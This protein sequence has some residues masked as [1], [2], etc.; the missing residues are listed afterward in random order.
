MTC[1][2]KKDVVLVTMP[3]SDFHMPS[4][5]LSLLKACLTR[6]GVDSVVQYEHL[7]FIK[8]FGL[9][10]FF[11]VQFS[12]GNF[13][14]G[15]IIFAKAAH[16]KTL[17]TPNEFRDWLIE[18]NIF[19]GADSSTATAQSEKT[20]AFIQKWQPFAEN[21]IE[22]A[23]ARVMAHKPKI[24]AFV[25]MFQQMNA[26]IALARRLKQEE[27][28]PIILVGGSNC[29]GDAGIALLEHFDA[30]DY[31]FIG[32]ADE[33]FADVCSALLRDGEIPPEKF[34][35]G[36]W[37]TRA[38]KPKTLVHR[39]T[40]NLDDLPVPDFDDFFK[41]HNELFPERKDRAYLM[42]EGSRGCWW[43]QH[44][45]CTFCGLNGFAR[46]YREK[47]T[48]R[49]ADEIK[50]LSETY[51]DAGVCMFTDSILSQRHTKELPAALKARNVKLKFFTEIKSNLSEDEIAALAQVNF[52][53]LQPGIES[54]QDDMLRLMNKGCRAIKQIE[55]LKLY[56]T[57][58]MTLSWNV[59]CGF[60][61]E[62]EEYMAEIVELMPLLMHFESP[63]Q[64]THIVY[65]R[66]GE[67]TENPERYGLSICPPKVYDFAFPDKDFIE[68]TTFF[69]EPT[70]KVA[71]EKYYG[72]QHMGKAYAAA[73]EIIDRWLVERDDPQRLDM[74][75]A[76]DEINI[77]DMRDV[78]VHSAYKLTGLKAELYRACRRV[79]SEKSLAK[80]FPDVSAETIRDELA[81]F[82]D[83]KIMIKIGHEYLALAVDA[84]PKVKKIALQRRR[85]FYD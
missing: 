3:F 15:E 19:A 23:A 62:R 78:A 16:E 53:H 77:F 76:G 68:R 47:S 72:C 28:P 8:S 21:Y 30:F 64:V 41:T 32:E 11:N 27:N 35:Y 6:A 25:S 63:N 9:R 66:Y 57:Y 31:V 26:N 24:V 18:K 45:P 17:G 48:E 58:N 59:L 61:G 75:D 60:P 10:N 65:H 83:D 22:E 5:A 84:N 79:Q 52:V 2:P 42:V 14:L 70:D 73:K 43:A 37:S 29:M 55:T 54:L 51:P 36:L 12:R 46:G 82:C 74:Y 13:M 34:P 44:K 38:P 80:I 20:L 1:V 71:L 7:H 49:L 69:F 4:M 81:A 50:L 40:K 33:I 39:V 67:Y 85:L 56:R